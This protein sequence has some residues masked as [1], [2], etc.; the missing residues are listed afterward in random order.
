M[1]NFKDWL[2]GFRV[3]YSK[4]P[5]FLQA[6]N[7]DDFEAFLQK[8][9]SVSIGGFD[10]SNI[11][12]ARKKEAIEQLHQ[13]EDLMIFD[14]SINQP[15]DFIKINTNSSN[16]LD[17]LSITD[18]QRLNSF[19][20][21]ILYGM[22]FEMDGEKVAVY[23][24]EKLKKLTE[25]YERLTTTRRSVDI[26]LNAD[27][28]KIIL[29]IYEALQ[30]KGA[31]IEQIK[32]HMPGMMPAE[33][34]KIAVTY[35]VVRD[36]SNNISAL[37]IGGGK[38]KVKLDWQK[39]KQVID[40][41]NAGDT[42]KITT[43]RKEIKALKEVM[44]RF[45]N[46]IKYKDQW[47]NI[48]QQVFLK[49][50]KHPATAADRKL[51]ERFVELSV[52]NYVKFIKDGYYDMILYPESSSSLNKM[53]AT[54]LGKHYGCEATLGFN[55]KEMITIDVHSFIKKN[56]HL[57][58]EKL[59]GALNRL[60]NQIVGSNGAIKNI[61][62]N[63]AFVRNWNVNSELLKKINKKIILV[64]DDNF[65]SGGTLQAINKVLWNVGS[66]RYVGYYVPLYANFS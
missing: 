35:D 22:K 15:E 38:S 56:S 36:A 48:I 41:S 64:V 24:K 16:M 66:P 43:L 2:E 47:N 19:K 3:D 42:P 32:K 63:Q 21:K 34:D 31:Y 44:D 14:R 33:L 11:L 55:K 5:D 60:R 27:I 37:M 20:S 51:Q 13:I 1:L 54:E 59:T 29:R 17:T 8:P 45:K 18:S 40:Q 49:K 12:G 61:S 7:D 46:N 57:S 39:I 28:Q 26:R 30:S 52:E 4:L 65:R 50:T 53:I 9:S 6:P 25:D 10:S 62:I 58:G 23:F